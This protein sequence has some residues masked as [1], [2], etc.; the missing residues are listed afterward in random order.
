MG[1]KLKVGLI[2][3]ENQSLSYTIY[4]L[5]EKSQT[6]SDYEIVA[7]IIHK[8][9]IKR[10]KSSENLTSR[11]LRK[12]K[13]LLFMDWKIF[14]R[15][16]LFSYIVKVEKYLFRK[17]PLI[18][19]IFLH[20][21]ISD[22]N[23]QCL[24]ITPTYSKSGLFIEHS[25]DE[26]EKIKK[27]N[28]D[29]LIRGGN[30]ILRGDILN[31]C[32][33]GILSFHHGDNDII[34]GGPA[35]FWE[36]FFKYSSTGF[37]LQKLTEELDGGNVL[38]KGNIPTRDKY[39]LNLAQLYIKSNIFLH[40]YLIKLSKDRKLSQI[41]PSRPYY[42]KL[43]VRPTVNEI[44]KYFYKNTLPY[45]SEIVLYKLKLKVPTVQRW[46]IAYQFIDNF[47]NV[48]LRKSKLIKNPENR[49]FAD[50]FVFNKD[51]RNII[52]V[53]DFYYD[54][55]KGVLS[56]IEVFKDKKPEILGTVI[57]EDFHLSFPY[58]FEV[59]GQL[60]MCPET[61]EKNEIRLYFCE[62]FP[63]KWKFHKT[64]MQN[65][66]AVDTLIF[67]K[68][69]LWYM[70]TNINSSIEVSENSSELHLYYA[71]SFDADN[72]VPHRD[73]PIIFN[74][75]YS[76]NGGLIVNMETIYRVFQK[77]DYNQYGKAMGLAKIIDISPNNYKEEYQF[78]IE[79]NFFNN[80]I[81]THSY[82]FRNG[83]LSLDYV[84]NE[85]IKSLK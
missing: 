68:D 14:L 51:N 21:T 22:Y 47:R 57:E 43:F 3:D 15:N 84:K 4:D 45:I 30:G 42:N 27:L 53:E 28:L 38:L 20:K 63:L 12:A 76:R 80:I 78:S 35:A 5:L 72:W 34:R 40:N 24:Y 67:Q 39:L 37:I 62:E 26:I 25:K 56:A 65:V 64:L 81:G 19:K 83:L 1:N 60:Y 71:S 82:S 50:P 52:F 44:G 85:P 59:D 8:S 49:F 2:V 36:V 77:Q 18:Q 61:S 33:F 66:K 55:N 69:N 73:N 7:F 23:I 10:D 79:P 70:L 6:Q 16:K 48:S 46:G 17:S 74:S 31:V 54:K 58:I 75:E 11:I 29:V 9:K 41:I 32:Q 13:T